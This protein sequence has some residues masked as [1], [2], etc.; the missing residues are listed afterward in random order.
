MA[1]INESS[2][3]WLHAWYDPLASLKTSTS[4]LRTGDLSSDGD[5]KLVVCD[6]EGKSMKVYKGTN[7]LLVNQ[8]LDTPVAC[9]I[10]YSDNA[11]PRIASIAVAAGQHIFIYRQLRPYKKWSCPHKNLQ[12]LIRNGA[13]C[14]KGGFLTISLLKPRKIY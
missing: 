10:L 11:S 6:I 4:L 3:L 12:N 1:E 9:C 5:M 8:L 7:L 14:L 13:C 2:A